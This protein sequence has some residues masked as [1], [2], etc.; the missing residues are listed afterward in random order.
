MLNNF[1]NSQNTKVFNKFY[2]EEKLWIMN[3]K[4]QYNPGLTRSNPDLFLPL[5]PYQKFLKKLPAAPFYA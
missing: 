3:S 2:P 5:T 4:K 1:P